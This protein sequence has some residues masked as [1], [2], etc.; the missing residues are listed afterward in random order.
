MYSVLTIFNITK[1][2]GPRCSYCNYQ[3]LILSFDCFITKKIRSTIYGEQ[4]ARVA[5][6]VTNETNSTVTVIPC[7]IMMLLR[8]VV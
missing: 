3:Q 4:H 8:V 5:N 1:L 7:G 2:F 6:D